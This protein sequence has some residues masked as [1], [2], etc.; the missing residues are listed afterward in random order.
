MKDQKRD[1][2]KRLKILNQ[3]KYDAARYGGISE[4]LNKRMEKQTK[5]RE[6]NL[7]VT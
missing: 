7:V 4:N 5:Q 6:K 2:V 1:T 3:T